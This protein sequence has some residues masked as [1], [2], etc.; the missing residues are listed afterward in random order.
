MVLAEDTKFNKNGQ[1][2]L[3]AADEVVWLE[4]RSG[5]KVINNMKDNVALILC[6][7]VTLI[8]F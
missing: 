7:L 6:T 4:N 8:V 3:D 2:L 5:Y 1:R